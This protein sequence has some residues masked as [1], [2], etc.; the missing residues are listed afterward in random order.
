MAATP[1]P[2]P[3]ASSPS[4]RSEHAE[5][6]KA[7]RD[8]LHVYHSK[9]A[10]L[11]RIDR[12]TSHV[13]APAYTVAAAGSHRVQFIF[14]GMGSSYFSIVSTVEWLQR[15]GIDAHARETSEWLAS[16]TSAVDAKEPVVPLRGW[17]NQH[18]TSTGDV[19]IVI[20]VS[21]SG[22]S[23]ELCQLID[24]WQKQHQDTSRPS[25]RTV[26]GST[27]GRTISA[28]NASAIAPA[29]ATSTSSSS[30]STTGSGVCSTSTCDTTPPVVLPLLWAI[31]NDQQSTLARAASEVFPTIAGHES[32]VGMHTHFVHFV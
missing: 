22:E 18:G 32:T 11:Q 4:F 25:T 2:T 15:R 24:Y 30:S 12:R 14:T 21:Q 9:P 31:T 3:A 5:I 16:I 19:T 1:T 10:V 20:A 7:I 26:S 28:S 23:G 6:P 29:A 8:T 27:G 13:L 17:T